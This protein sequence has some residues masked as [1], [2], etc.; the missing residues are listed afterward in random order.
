LSS[1]APSSF[2]K[3]PLSLHCTTLIF[4]NPLLR[5]S[6]ISHHSSHRLKLASM[7]I[8]TSIEPIAAS[9]EACDDVDQ[10]TGS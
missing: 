4:L 6:S 7:T 10:P 9:S 5:S 1:I 8:S 2:P 3:H